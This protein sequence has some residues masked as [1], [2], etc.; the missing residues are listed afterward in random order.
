MLSG[1]ARC[2]ICGG[3]LAALS[4]PHGRDR[5]HFYGCT[6]F[7]KR[8]ANV[9]T[10]NLVARIET[11]DAQL[12]AT[13]QDDILR[14]SVVE[15]AIAFALEELSPQRRDEDHAAIEREL[16]TVGAECERLAEAI[17]RGGPLDALLEHLRGR[18]ERCSELERVLR[19]SGDPYADVR[20]CA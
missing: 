5:V 3:G 12:L 8:G 20:L 6:S 10:N 14:P 9:C 7:W 16:A 17:G 1:F 11:I 15:K 4:R 13:L 2:G 19:V 18:Q